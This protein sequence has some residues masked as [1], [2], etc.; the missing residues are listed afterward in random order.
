MSLEL[1]R[2]IA[3]GE[4]D[5]VTLAEIKKCARRSGAA[6]FTLFEGLVT[7]QIRILFHNAPRPSDAAVQRFQTEEFAALPA[8]QASIQ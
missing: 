6:R 5:T 7:R 1:L 8:H 4:V 2:E 3:W